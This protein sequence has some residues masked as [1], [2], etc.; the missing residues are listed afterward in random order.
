MYLNRRMN[1]VQLQCNYGI[2]VSFIIKPILLA[3]RPFHVHNASGNTN[4]Q[5]D[6]ISKLNLINSR[7]TPGKFKF[8]LPIN[9]LIFKQT[10]FVSNTSRF[11]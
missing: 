10:L 3:H 5:N 9:L 6:S 7:N 4:T 8:V 1:I 11:G 2:Y